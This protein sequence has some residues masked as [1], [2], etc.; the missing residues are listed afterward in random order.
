MEI[1]QYSEADGVFNKYKEKLAENQSPAELLKY[2]K[3]KINKLGPVTA[4]IAVVR[5]IELQKK[6]LAKYQEK[7][8]NK[9]Y[10]KALENIENKEKERHDIP[11]YI[12]DWINEVEANGFILKTNSVEIDYANINK[13]A[14]SF[15]SDELKDYI[16]IE[17]EES[18]KKYS[19]IESLDSFLV[20]KQNKLETYILDLVNAL[21]K[22][23]E[24]TNTYKDSPHIFRVNQLKSEYLHIF[25]LGSPNNS[26][27]KYYQGYDK[28]DN[29][30]GNNWKIAY[31]LVEAKYA[32]DSRI[33]GFISNYINDL[34]TN[35]FIL[36]ENLYKK[37]NDTIS[38]NQ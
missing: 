18:I 14:D 25:L 37:I 15:V 35:K 27:F 21:D 28:P 23:Y 7:L 32:K 31:S 12:R 1:P 38:N 36:N 17:S 33:G 20:N 19:Q 29:V 30:I 26:A 16:K 24:Y 11:K 13:V 6:L 3:N 2:L 5:I 4:D 8:L 34:T 22:T 10:L 9:E